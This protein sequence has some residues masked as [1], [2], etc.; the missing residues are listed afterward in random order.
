MK[1]SKFAL[2]VDS[3]FS[4]FSITFIIYLWLNKIYKN[5][6]L[7][8]FISIIV[9]ILSFTLFLIFFFK[10]NNKLISKSNNEK[11]LNKCINSLILS[12]N[13]DYKNFICKL[14]NCSHIENY[15]Y[16]LEDKIIY[17]NIKTELSSNDYFNMQEIIFNKSINATKLY[18]IY[19]TKN[20]SFD[21]IISISNYE[22][23][24]IS[25]EILAKL[26]TQ[27]NIYP[28]KKES[29]TKHSLKNKII[30]NFK[31]QYQSITN[32]HFKEFFFSGL[33]LLFL[34]IIV[35][36]S[37]YYL[38]IGTILLIISILSL[39]RKNIEPSSNNTDFLFEQK[40]K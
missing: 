3:L 7:V 9:L 6:N 16:K 23:E 35:P 39:F 28:I 20:K 27:K 22:I 38:I 24:L 31:K 2:F 34:S 8:N 18:F 26:M 33:S 4:S 40:Q 21:D 13:L 36:F 5:A 1:K 12:S 14:L 25:F 19:K 15:T 32:K 29:V 10:H 17:I 11:F 37:N 30:N